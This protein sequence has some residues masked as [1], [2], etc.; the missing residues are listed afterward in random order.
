MLSLKE[1]LEYNRAGLVPGPEETETAYLRRVAYNLHLKGIKELYP[2]QELTLVRDDPLLMDEVRPTLQGLYDLDPDWIP[3]MYSSEGLSFFHGGCT[4]ITEPVDATPT[5][6]W[7]Q[8]RP[9]LKKKGRLWGWYGM[10]EIVAHEAAHIGRMAFQE[11]VFEELLAYRS[12]KAW[13]R[14]TL[15]PIVAGTREVFFFFLVILAAMIFSVFAIFPN[16]WIV[17][18]MVLLI[19]IA[20]LS[21]RLIVFHSTLEVLQKITPSKEAANAVIYRLTDHEI[22]SFSDADPEDILR[23][24]QHESNKSLRWRVLKAA[25]FP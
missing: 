8:I 19:A 15:G 24:A 12:S 4:C 13:W 22:F 14:R 2:D 25:Y 9:G 3:M 17:W 21:A 11:S 5:V 10:K 1:L 20:R 7:L 23:Y 6:A 18:V 16:A